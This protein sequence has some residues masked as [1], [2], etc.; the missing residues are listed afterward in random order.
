MRNVFAVLVAIVIVAG[1]SR[2]AFAQAEAR[3]GV[4]GTK[5]SSTHEDQFDV[6]VGWAFY[7]A[8]HLD[9]SP[10]SLFGAPVRTPRGYERYTWSAVASLRFGHEWG[11]GAASEYLFGLRVTDRKRFKFPIFAEALAGA[12]HFSGSTDVVL[13]PSAGVLFGKADRN[14]GFYVKVGTPLFLFTGNAEIGL[15]AG[16]GFWFGGAR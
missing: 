13:R 16:A 15:E 8:G 7:S 14:H 6:A 1:S 12:A 3:A 5:A 11:G 4:A 10:S 2:T 9:R